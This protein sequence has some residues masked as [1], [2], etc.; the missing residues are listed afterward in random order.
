MGGTPPGLQVGRF[1][2]K[3]GDGNGRGLDSAT[4]S[5]SDRADAEDWGLAL[6]I[7]AQSDFWCG[8][9]FGAIGVATILLARNYRMG[10][11]ARMGPGYFPT[12]LGYLLVFLGLTLTLP[13]LFVDGE[14]IPRVH[15]RPVLIVLLSIVLFGLILDLLG[16]AL[17]VFVLAL[18]GG[19]A[20]PELRARE[21]TLLALFLAAF[22]VV[23]F[24]SLLGLPLVLWPNF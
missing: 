4:C 21:A 9:L 2:F 1:R 22:S 15:P 14:K 5:G 10:T 18:V 17:S 19:F 11:A 16:F 7:R 6:R 8:L 3:P 13:S 23:I 20:E 24:H 12:L